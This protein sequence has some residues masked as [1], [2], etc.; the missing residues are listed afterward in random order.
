MNKRIILSLASALLFLGSCIKEDLSRCPQ[1]KYIVFETIN[2]KYP[3]GQ[4]VSKVDLYL[5]DDRETLVGRYTYSREQLQADGLRARLPKQPDGN[6]FLVALVNHE[7]CFATTGAET[8]STLRTGVKTEAGDSVSFKLADIY[9]GC[10]DI[11]FVSSTSESRDKV[12]LS[13]NT[14]NVNLTVELRDADNPQAT[15]A[16]LSTAVTGTNGT[17][18]SRNTPVGTGKLTYLPHTTK[19]VS[20]LHDFRTMRMWIGDDLTVHAR[21]TDNGQ[22]QSLPLTGT[23]SGMEIDGYKPYDT[24]EKLE[25]EDEFDIH[26]VFDGQMT[27]V[28]LKINDWYLIKQPGIDL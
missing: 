4:I 24:D 16:L 9:H 11:S 25:L 17:Y 22:Q 12:Y 1:G 28:A 2:P 13:K 20:A 10:K 26:V 5:Y 27:I 8:R 6:Y 14:N 3:F 7:D 23:L 19:A 15:A 21:R 18:D